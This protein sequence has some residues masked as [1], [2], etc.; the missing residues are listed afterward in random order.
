MKYWLSGGMNEMTDQWMDE[1]Q[2]EWS[3]DIKWSENRLTDWLAVTD[4]KEF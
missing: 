4:L 1:L 2:S 3:E